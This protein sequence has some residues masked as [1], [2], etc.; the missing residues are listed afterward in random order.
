MSFLK[1]IDDAISEGSVARDIGRKAQEHWS[2][3]SDTYER[4]GY[5]RHSAEML[6]GEDTKAW[7][8][9]STAQGRHIL[10]ARVASIRRS[11]QRVAT[12]PPDKLQGLQ[13][14]TVEAID[15]SQRALQRHFNNRLSD[16]LEK[17]HPNLIGNIKDPVLMSNVTIELHGGNT[18]S[19]A[20]K[21]V[22]EAVQTALEDMRIMFNE[23]GGLIGKRDNFGLPH[24]HDRGKI[25]KAGFEDWSREIIDNN[26]LD[27]TQMENFATGR[28]FQIEGAAPPSRAMQERFLREIY[29][30]I[31]FGK[32]S[33]EAVYGQGSGQALYKQGSEARV[34]QFRSGEDW[35][36]YNKAYGTGDAYNSLMTH[37]ANMAGDI[38]TMRSLGP[39]PR[40]GLDYQAQLI[41]GRVRKEG[42]NPES[43]EFDLCIAERML[44]VLRGPL[45][46]EGK[47]G[48]ISARFFSA[49]RHL[50]TAA[51]LDKAVVASISDFNSMRL[52]AGIVN[53]GQA[54]MFKTYG[55]NMA[56]MIKDGSM[57]TSQLRRDK[58]VMDTLA[59][60]VAVMDRFQMEIPPGAFFERLV[61]TSMKV[62]GLSQHTD[63]ARYAFQSSLWGVYADNAGKAFKDVDPNFQ[64]M[65]REHGVSPRDW[66]DFRSEGNTY[67]PE[68]GVTFLN[69]LYWRESTNLGRQRADEVF[70]AMQGLSERWTEIAV[71]TSNLQ[72]RAVFD[73][74]AW[75]L[76][77]GSFG[78]EFGKSAGMFKS[79]VMAFTVNQY[80]MI[81]RQ[82]TTEA[83][84]GYVAN[85]VG[86]ATVMGALSLQLGEILK[87]NDPM[88]MD[89]TDLTF[90]ENAEF[91]GR[92]LLKG[93]GAGPLADII[94]V[95][96]ASWG[97][98]F[99]S[100]LGG[101]VA[102]MFNDAWTLGPSNAIN[103]AGD[104]ARGES[105]DTGFAKEFARMGRRYTPMGQTPLIGPAMDRLVWD[106]LHQVMDP[107]GSQAIDR[108]ARMRENRDGNA[109]WWLPGAP[110]PDRVPNIG[111]LIGG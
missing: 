95:G 30:N 57:T 68:A 39:N 10:Q 99:G 90:M 93:G 55:A 46:P 41:A 14:H 51:F 12:T 111:K 76:A 82:P 29:D 86:G 53:G 85:L 24:S 92:A 66:D 54:N 63:N 19:A 56:A 5:D 23:A 67:E 6:A 91:W 40:M 107:E 16:L 75:G 73:P 62:Q 71:P 35:I 109:S 110:M 88:N 106:Q 13:R 61:A 20:A 38:A 26:R 32:G 100:Y 25:V 104:I 58:W 65:M 27:W 72:A 59:D 9:K 96:E 1:C 47:W 108:A 60:P 70:L 42:L 103:A 7:L 81:V 18:G 3:L 69:P 33:R 49:S 97:G 43:F 50:M 17:V 84:V 37:A 28:P 89:P 34:L 80:R 36:A 87:G 79:F 45:A 21:A 83:R 64:Q 15:Y 98:G 105:V 74:V 94:I 48:R 78:Y 22:S 8:T 44:R 52:T 31:N 4:Q 11:E 101:P 102:Q 2:K 77:P